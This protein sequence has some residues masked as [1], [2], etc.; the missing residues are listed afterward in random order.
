MTHDHP[1]PGT[2]LATVTSDGQTVDLTLVMRLIGAAYAGCRQCQVEL[3]TQVLDGPAG[4]IN[5]VAGAA[6]MG[7]RSFAGAMG[8]N[9]PMG[10]EALRR[11]RALEPRPAEV[12]SRMLEH[13]GTIL[14]RHG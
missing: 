1:T 11:Y 2:P 3:S 5:H 4:V 6:Y 9:G 8:V 13:L 10:E 14:V 7:M 12:E